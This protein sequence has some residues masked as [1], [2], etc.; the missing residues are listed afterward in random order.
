MHPLSVNPLERQLI[1]ILAANREDSY[2]TQRK[3]GY[4]LASVAA[5][6]RQRFGLQKWDNLKAK[7]ILQIV[8]KWKS[9]DRGRRGIEEKLSHLRW[10][11]R[12]IGKAN[13][14]PR[15]NAELGVEAG[16]R[17]T[18]AGK[19]I[20]DDRFAQ[21]LAA[22]PDERV[23]AM[24][25]LAR[26]VGLRFKES[27]LFR[28]GRDWQG[29]RVWVKRGTKGGHPRYLFLHNPRQAEVLETARSLAPGDSCLIPQEVRTY[30]EW[31]QYVYRALRAAGIGR[32]TDQTFHDLR[33]T[34]FNERMVFLVKKKGMSR[35]QAATLVAREAGHHRLEILDWYIDDSDSATDAS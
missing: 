12:K 9:Q 35:D 29:D 15:S 32:A 19:V 24:M 33:R 17:H 1:S 11:V 27:S 28:P 8:D 25:L 3:R 22:V 13:L 34:Y 6:L 5:A 10:I 23:K 7:H 14:V 30:E 21:M 2:A 16:P 20:P 31:R 26:H 4:V 18:R